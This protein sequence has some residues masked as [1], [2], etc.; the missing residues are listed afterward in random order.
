MRDEPLDVSVVIGVRDGGEHLLRTV[1]SV[2]A[3]RDVALEC[4]VVDDGSSD[5]TG[6][7][8]AALASSDR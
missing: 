8:I 4:I 6:A 2:C 3:Q 7:R 5:V 1:R